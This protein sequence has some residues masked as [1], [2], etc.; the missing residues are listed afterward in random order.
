LWAHEYKNGEN[1]CYA[2]LTTGAMTDVAKPLRQLGGRRWRTMDG[3]AWYSYAES[4]EKGEGTSGQ[5]PQIRVEQQQ[6]GQHHH[7]QDWPVQLCDE[8]LP[9][10]GIAA[11]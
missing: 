9:V 4:H 7:Q 5:D 11:R 3:G 8:G 6:G 2:L 10:L 1:F